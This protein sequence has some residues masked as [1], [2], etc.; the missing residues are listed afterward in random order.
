MPFLVH[1]PRWYI[2]QSCTELIEV[3]ARRTPHM[4]QLSQHSCLARTP[5]PGRTNGRTAST[6][7]KM[8]NHIIFTAGAWWCRTSS[9]RREFHA[10]EHVTKSLW[11]RSSIYKL[12]TSRSP[13]K[14]KTHTGGT[15]REREAHI[16]RQRVTHKRKSD[17]LVAR[18]GCIT[19]RTLRAR[20]A[21]LIYNAFWHNRGRQKHTPRFC[22]L[23]KLLLDITQCNRIWY[24][25]CS[26]YFFGPTF[27]YVAFCTF[28]EWANTARC[29]CCCLVHAIRTLP[30]SDISTQ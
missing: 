3:P 23:L 6:S 10:S 4:H 15:E 20:C 27:V 17:V 18:T 12:R 24:A 19:G 11:R 29:C 28:H 2:F 25:P 1:T 21:T 30:C 13:T 14:T 5:I 16:M 22:V 8:K 9:R 26:T 7:W